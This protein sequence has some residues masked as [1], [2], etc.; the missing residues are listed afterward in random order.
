[1]ILT[2]QTKFLDTKITFKLLEPRIQRIEIEEKGPTESDDSHNK[3][4]QNDVGIEN[5]EVTSNSIKS[6]KR[7]LV[8]GIEDY[9][10]EAKKI[11]QIQQTDVD[12]NKVQEVI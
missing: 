6:V 2:N 4:V 11:D 12:S 10:D 5:C 3:Q 9:N 7:I 1:M 8:R